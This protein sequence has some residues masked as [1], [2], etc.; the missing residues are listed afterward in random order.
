[1]PWR[2]GEDVTVIMGAASLRHLALRGGERG[3]ARER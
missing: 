3:I 1:M 2:G